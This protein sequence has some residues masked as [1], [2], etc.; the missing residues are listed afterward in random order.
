[1]ATEPEPLVS[2]APPPGYRPCVGVMLLDRDGRV[3]VGQ[4]SD[5][6]FESWQMPQG[7]IDE[8]EDPR[9]AA[10]REL[11]EET[12]IEQAELLAESR[13][14]LAYDLPKGLAPQAWGG[15]YRGQSQKWFAFR[16]TGEDDDIDLDGHQAEFRG[17][18]WVSADELLALIVDFKR[19]VYRRVVDE[20]RHLWA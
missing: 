6:P 10:L 14:W 4:R 2:D 18:R 3:L 8:G 20:F 5:M 13:H 11:R 16:F 12:G 9:T 17:W 19:P 7:G 15:R 1:M